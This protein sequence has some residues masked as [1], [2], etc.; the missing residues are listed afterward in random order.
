MTESDTQKGSGRKVGE[1][2]MIFRFARAYP[3]RI[4]AAL[5]SLIIA[6]AATLAIP[7]GLRLVIDKGFIASGGDVGT[8]FRYLLVIVLVLALRLTGLEI[9]TLEKRCTRLHLAANR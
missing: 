5:V 7:G 9:V 3:G 2:A 8:Y 1:L 6:S 4:A